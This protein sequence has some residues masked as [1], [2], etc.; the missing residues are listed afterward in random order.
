MELGDLLK[1]RTYSV[2][3]TKWKIFETSVD[4]FSTKGYDG[5]GIREIADAVGIKSASIYNHFDNKSAIL[6]RMFNFFNDNY[7]SAQRPVGELLKELPEKSFSDVLAELLPPY[8]KK[9]YV[10]LSKI[11]VIAEAQSNTNA[12]AY[13]LVVKVAKNIRARL[14]SVLGKMQEL[15]MIEPIDSDLFASLFFTYTMSSVKR[16]DD[17]KH[18][19]SYAE[20]QAGRRL[21]F[22]IIREKK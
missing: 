2:A 21:L 10:I 17:P 7:F 14:M 6:V 18:P 22:E 19:L 15:G 1:T 9:T 5:V 12:A 4:L 13:D 16:V 3:G 8:D 20:W 11:L